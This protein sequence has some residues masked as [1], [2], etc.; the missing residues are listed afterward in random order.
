M[1]GE[2][3]AM[4]LLVQIPIVAITIYFYSKVLRSKK[5]KS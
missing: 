5:P 4:L 1:K 3:L 2:A